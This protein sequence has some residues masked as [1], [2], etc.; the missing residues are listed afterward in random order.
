MC[1]GLPKRKVFRPKN[2]PQILRTW[3]EYDEWKRTDDYGEDGDDEEVASAAAVEIENKRRMAQHR[4]RCDIQQYTL[5]TRT[6]DTNIFK[7]FRC[8]TKEHDLPTQNAWICIAFYL[9]RLLLLL[10]LHPHFDRF[11]GMISFWL[12][13]LRHIYL[14]L[15]LVE[16][17]ACPSGTTTN[18]FRMVLSAVAFT[19]PLHN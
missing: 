8:V 7:L 14:S 13:K 11:F 16:T 9:L 18:I 12:A 3:N 1:L 5:C 15:S 6:D 2:H 19:R 17:I 10:L 4:M